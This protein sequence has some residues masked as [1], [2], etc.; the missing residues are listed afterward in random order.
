[1][2][3]TLKKKV[4]IKKLSEI[5]KLKGFSKQ[6]QKAY[7]YHTSKFIEFIEKTGLNIS[8]ESVKCY[9]L[10]KDVS[11][12]S[13]RLMH[14]SIK[15]FF[16]NI[17]NKPFSNQEVPIKKKEKL[18]PKVISKKNIIKMIKNTKNLKHKIIIKLLYSSGLRISELLNLKREDIDFEKNLIY[19]KKGKGN[20]DRITI[21]SKSLKLDILKYYS[22]ENFKTRY[23]IEGRS[24]KYSKKSVQTIIKKAG[25]NIGINLHPH[26][27]RHSFATH[28]LEQGVD[29]RYIQK[30]L[31]HSD[32]RTTQIYTHVKT[33]QLLS[34]SSPL[35]T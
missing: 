34:I 13:A 32:N 23:I 27:L 1:M 17:L 8:N 30:L 3:Y 33:D 15:F 4:W 19:V 14:A 6:T 16:D 12:N 7:C 22:K 28:L 11:V 2:N 20:K 10:S 29:L 24:G 31:G 21:M 25:K 18:L 35:D 5:C 26:M 9:I